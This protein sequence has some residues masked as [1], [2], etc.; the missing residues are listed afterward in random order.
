MSAI[1]HQV[2]HKRPAK[3]GPD[4]IVD[5][6]RHVDGHHDS[7]ELASHEHHPGGLDSDVCAVSDR[8]PEVRLDAGAASRGKVKLKNAC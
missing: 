4:A 7:A 2:V 3:V 6:A 5:G 1:S 8:Q